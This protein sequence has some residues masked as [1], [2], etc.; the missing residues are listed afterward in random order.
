LVGGCVW[1]LARF[2]A[3]RRV[4]D[5]GA[6]EGAELEQALLQ[7]SDDESRHSAAEDGTVVY[8]FDRGNRARTPGTG[9]RGAGRARVAPLAAVATAT[10]RERGEDEAP[11]GVRAVVYNPLAAG[12]PSPPVASKG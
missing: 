12:G 7:G 9:G 4:R 2:C 5:V 10:D 8:R 11:A 1:V 6:A 3:R